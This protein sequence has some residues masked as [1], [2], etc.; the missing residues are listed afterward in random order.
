MSKKRLVELLNQK[1]NFGTIIVDSQIDDR[2][3]QRTEISNED[4]ADYLLANGVYVLPCKI[5]DYIEWDTGLEKQLHQVRGF[6]YRP[7][8]QFEIFA[9]RFFTDCQRR[10]VSAYY[11]K[12]R[13]RSEV[14]KGR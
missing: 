10:K 11:S 13:S 6:L 14:K 9:Q 5:G 12:R 4:I 1:Q 7:I 8:R 3:C 2:F